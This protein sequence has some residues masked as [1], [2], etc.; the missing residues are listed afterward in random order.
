MDPAAV[1]EALGGLSTVGPVGTL[2]LFVLA[3]GFGWLYPRA[4]MK[5]AWAEKDALQATLDGQREKFDDIAEILGDL[6]AASELTLHALSEI[7]NAGSRAV[8][9]RDSGGET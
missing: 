1:I 4:Q 8:Q 2:T 3:L 7:Q 6:K 5:R 9:Q